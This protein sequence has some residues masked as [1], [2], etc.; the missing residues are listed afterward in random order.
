MKPLETRIVSPE[1][2]IVIPPEFL[3]AHNIK[4]GDKVEVTLAST[5]IKIQKYY[6]KNVCVVTGK[7]SKKGKMVGEAFISDEGMKLIEKQLNES[8]EK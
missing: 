6:E 4:P 5:Y 1:N 2:R 7:V 3:K 8:K